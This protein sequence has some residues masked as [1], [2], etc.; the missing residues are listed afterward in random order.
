MRRFVVPGVITVVI[1]ALLAVLAFGVSHEGTSQV[2]V[3]QVQAGHHPIAPDSKM[4]LQ[5]LGSNTKRETLASLRGK[6][7][8]INFY[9]GWCQS[10]QIE[11][12]LIR[13]AERTLKAHG[14]TVLGITYQDSSSDALS[15]LSQYHLSLPTLRDP[16]GAFAQAYGITG[17]P[18]TFIVNRQGRVEA[19][20]TYELTRGWLDRTLDK[21]LG[22]N[23]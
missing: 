6:V 4:P 20:N 22:I 5:V 15:Y 9:A 8:M 18:E 21:A 13:Q 16:T 19:D 1:L 17:V 7:V 3:S 23:T 10:C 2:L 14:G 11:A 12:P